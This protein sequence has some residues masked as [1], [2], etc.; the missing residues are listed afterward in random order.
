M[1]KGH[2]APR[3]GLIGLGGKA[4]G[5]HIELFLKNFL[6]SGSTKYNHSHKA[7]QVAWEALC[8]VLKMRV[9]L[10]SERLWIGTMLPC[11]APLGHLLTS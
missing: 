4:V 5:K 10:E 3:R 6:W 8:F 7:G 1:E 2:L 11:K 9:V